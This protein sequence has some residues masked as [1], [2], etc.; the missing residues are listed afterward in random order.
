MI[1]TLNS[2]LVEKIWTRET[3]IEM[4]EELFFKPFISQTNNSPIK[5][6]KELAAGAGDTI[7]LNFI[8][9]LSGEGTDGDNNVEGN[10]EAMN[11]YDFSMQINQKRHAVK[12]KGRME[13]QKTKIQLRTKA[14]QLLGIWLAEITEKECFR[15]LGGL[16]S[17]TFSNT[18]TAPSSN[19]IM[20]GGDAT[21]DSDIDSSDKM[22][23]ALIFK[24]SNKLKTLTPLFAPIRYKGKSW[25]V[26]LIHPRQRNDLFNDPD[27]IKFMSQ[28]EVRGKE[29]PLVSGADAIVDNIIIHVHNWV[30]T[31]STWGSGGNLPGARALVLGAQALG[32]AL[33][34]DTGWVEEA[35]DYRNKWGICTGRIFGL[36]K[37]KFNSEDLAVLAVDTYAA[38]I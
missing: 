20:Y 38:S 30:P 18:P 21:S 31:F 7:Y 29:N 6:Q 13:E 34:K 15:K 36:Q 12:L 28:V 8:P 10:E 23:L 9:K 24:I 11:E 4:M 33:G 16:T 37:I 5:L 14:K 1:S 25:Y 2:N 35:F 19:R 3:L 22:T 26:M 27:Y 32:Y 17:Y